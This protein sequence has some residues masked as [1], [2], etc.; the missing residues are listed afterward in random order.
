MPPSIATDSKATETPSLPGSTVGDDQLTVDAGSEPTEVEG[1]RAINDTDTNSGAKEENKEEEGEKEE[2]EPKIMKPEIKRLINRYSKET[3]QNTTVEAS[4]SES[5]NED[6]WAY[7]AICVTNLFNYRNELTRRVLEIKAP[8]LKNV[9]KNVVGDGYPGVSF[10]TE[11]VILNY[12]LRSLFHNLQSIQEECVR[13]EKTCTEE[14]K[15]F[16]HLLVGFL[17]EEL[18]EDIVNVNSLLPEGRI[19]YDLYASRYYVLVRGI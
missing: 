18:K 13:L 9:L 7:T 8:L 5:S 15:K 16:L 11:R 3:G 6:K 1:A 10:K 19:T 14:E 2:E 4:L 17:K 12:P